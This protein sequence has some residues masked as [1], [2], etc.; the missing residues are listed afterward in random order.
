MGSKVCAIV[1][2]GAGVGAAVAR[3]FAA[4]GYCIAM[5]SRDAAKL[6][7]YEHELAARGVTAQGFPADPGSDESVVSAIEVMREAMP[8]P[9]VLIFNASVPRESAPSVLDPEALAADLRIGVVGAL[10]AARAVLP[11]MRAIGQGS[12]LF[13][14]G[15]L[16]MEPVAAA[17]SLSVQKA[18]LRNL[19]FSLHQEL[20]PAGV[21]AAIVTIAGVLR[22]GSLLDDARVADA[23]WTLHSQPG[24]QFSR[25]IVLS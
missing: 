9:E 17:A 11:S 22:E 15:G 25:E 23:F 7:R 16:A 14:G 8:P 3:R 1:G 21:H 12:I 18:A 5:I 13:T 6:E 10:I 2:M 19:V 24:G 4:E 20:S